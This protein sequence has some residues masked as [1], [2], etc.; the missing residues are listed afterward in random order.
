MTA[1]LADKEQVKIADD[2]LA[3]LDGIPI[4][5]KVERGGIIYVQFQDRDR[6]RS[7]CRG[8]NFVEIPFVVLYAIMCQQEQGNNGK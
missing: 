3:R 1:K 8:T 5:R 4:F 6:M 7:Q 2:G